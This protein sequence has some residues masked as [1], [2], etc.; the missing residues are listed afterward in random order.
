MWVPHELMMM[1]YRLHATQ[2]NCEDFLPFFPISL[3]PR[4]RGN[5]KI[6]SDVFRFC[7]SLLFQKDSCRTSYPKASSEATKWSSRTRPT[8][9][10]TK[11]IISSPDS[12][13][14]W[15]D[16]RASTTSAAI[17][18][19]TVKVKVAQS[20][21]SLFARRNFETKNCVSSHGFSRRHRRS[22]QWDKAILELIDHR[23]RL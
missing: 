8:M 14:L 17:F 11:A 2:R 19:D 4:P 6:N 13:S 5:P 1:I 15:T 12:A 16:K 21:F 3:P 22:R 10:K 9:A 20:F 7:F 18:T 23:T